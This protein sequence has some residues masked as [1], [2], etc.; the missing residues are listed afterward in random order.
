MNRFGSFKKV[1]RLNADTAT[2]FSSGT[3]EWIVKQEVIWGI[4]QLVY[5]LQ[6]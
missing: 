6:F 3:H 2:D 1:G 5:R 4:V